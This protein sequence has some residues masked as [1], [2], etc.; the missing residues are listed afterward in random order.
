M[1]LQNYVEFALARLREQ[2][3]R[4]TR[5]RRLV[6]DVLGRA[7]RPVSPY[8]IHDILS[9]QG[10]AVDTVS[11]YRT[12]ETLEN[13]GLIHRVAFSGGYLP[14]RLEDHPGC[15]HHLICRECGLVEEVD[16]PGMAAVER[17]ASADS[18]FRIERHLV[19]F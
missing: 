1:S 4:I 2:G 12:L 7:Q 15:H 11:I 6:L 13:A 17:G 10:E 9:E 8:S 5:G 19:E 3:C 18:R 14:C 16:C